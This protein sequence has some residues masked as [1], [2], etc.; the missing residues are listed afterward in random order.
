MRHPRRAW[1]SR[2]CHHIFG[3]IT[4]LVPVIHVLLACFLGDKDADGRVKPGHDEL[5][6][7]RE[8]STHRPAHAFLFTSL[9]LEKLMPSA[10]S[11]V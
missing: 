8:A 2:E 11:L 9:M 10:R 1:V 4:G 3:V 6:D 7:W 5:R